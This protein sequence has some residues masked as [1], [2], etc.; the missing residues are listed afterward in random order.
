MSE[1]YNED[2]KKNTKNHNRNLTSIDNID[3]NSSTKFRIT[4]PRSLS[5]MRKLGYENSELN[6]ITYKEFL[7]RNPDLLGAKKEIS[8]VGY[9]FYESKRQEKLEK[10]KNLR[11]EEIENE[12]N[13]NE[14]SQTKNN[15]NLK[16][17]ENTQSTAIK[18]E[19]KAFERMK[20]KNEKDLIGMVQYELRREIM[21]KQAEEQLKQQ[22][23]KIQRLKDELLKSR[24]EEEKKK[25]E[26]EKQKELEQKQ[27]E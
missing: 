17:Q 1:N 21:K 6:F 15:N 20:N 12:K 2:E 10:L 25:R 26:K 13:R 18:N 22:N 4:S 5:A 11:D 27:Q 19:M 7:K 23:E 14:N 9:E 16:N 24:K 8:K 3:V